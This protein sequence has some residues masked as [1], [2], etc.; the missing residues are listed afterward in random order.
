MDI[1]RDGEKSGFFAN[2]FCTKANLKKK[3]KVMWD[4]LHSNGC[5]K[6]EEHE[7]YLNVIKWFNRCKFRMKLSY[8]ALVKQQTITEFLMEGIL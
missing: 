7:L 1:N 5:Y 4:T 8:M 6:D 3:K 2:M